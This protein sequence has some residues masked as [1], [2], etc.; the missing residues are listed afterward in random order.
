VGTVPRGHQVYSGNGFIYL[1]I[2][3]PFQPP[4]LVTASHVF[5]DTE[6]KAEDDKILEA[7]PVFE[8]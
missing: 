2:W 3:L 6:I 1:L 4:V 5:M 7:P 8:D